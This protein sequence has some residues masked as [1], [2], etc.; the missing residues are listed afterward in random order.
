MSKLKSLNMRGL[1]LWVLCGFL[2]LSIAGCASWYTRNLEFSRAFESGNLD[3]ALTFYGNKKLEKGKNR[4]IYWVNLGTVQSIKGNYQE[5]NNWLEKAYIYNE[6][7]SK[8]VGQVVLSNITNPEALDY[9][10]EDHEVMMVNYYKALN[11]LKMGMP[12]EA[13]VECKRMENQLNRLADKYSADFKYQ[14]DAFVNLLMGM[15]YD[16]NKDYNNAFI[17]YRN[18]YEIYKGDFT[19]FFGLGSPLQLKKDLIRTAALTGFEDYVA[20]Y[21]QEFNLKYEK[22]NSGQGTVV[23]LW[24][25]GLGP[26]KKEKSFNF[27]TVKGEGGRFDFVSDEMAFAVPYTAANPSE[28]SN[29][30]SLSMVRVA[31]PKYVERQTVFNSASVELNGLTFPIEEAYDI[32][33]IAEKVLRQRMLKEISKA[34]VRQ[35][36]KQALIAASRAAAEAATKGDKKESAG[37]AAALITTLLTQVSEKA[38]TRNWQTLPHSIGIARINVHPGKHSFK[39]KAMAKNGFQN[40]EQNYEVE[41]QP[42]GT[43]YIT[44]HSLDYIHQPNL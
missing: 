14:K 42:G 19:K 31:F 2:A 23:F 33:A 27:T 8:K 21:T 40:Q 29:L 44:H 16:A 35:G 17:A 22:P 39:F 43:V 26:V 30:G 18:A 3:K 13:M 11:Y 37:D 1:R 24:H 5:S 32:N 12:D 36:V 15:I 10:A 38:D 28:A 9:Q 6:D 41:V 25:N 34:I 4:M 7:Y 20:K